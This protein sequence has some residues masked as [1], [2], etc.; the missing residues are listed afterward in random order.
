MHKR[1]LWQMQGAFNLDAMGVAAFI[2][3]SKCI[4]GQIRAFATRCG[5]GSG[6]IFVIKKNETFHRQLPF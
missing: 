1:V 2:D 6:L 3:I 4:E 5:Q